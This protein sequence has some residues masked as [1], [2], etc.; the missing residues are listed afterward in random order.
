MIKSSWMRSLMF[1]LLC[2]IGAVAQS[3]VFI[4]DMEGVLVRRSMRKAIWE[5]GPLNFIGLFNHLRLE[6]LL[7][8]FMEQIVPYDKSIPQV[9]MDNGR[10]MSAFLVLWM[11]GR[12]TRQEALELIEKTYNRLKKATDSKRKIS[13]LKEIVTA[14][15]TPERFM[16]MMDPVHKGVKLLKKCYKAKNSDGSKKNRVF[17]LSNWDSESFRLMTAD[18]DFSDFLDMTDG[19]LVSADVHYVKPQPEIFEHFFTE[20]DVNPDS[21]LT[22]YID[23]NPQN[24]LAAQGLGKRLLRPILCKNFN[25]KSI[26]KKLKEFDVF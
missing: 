16:R 9:M 25:F 20:F 18:S 10:R 21:E 17:I 15:V 3:A 23:D 13:L 8:D 4:F 2:G 12:I 11:Q 6:D 7:Y 24:I 1:A 22:I 26:K 5:V 14:I 19:A